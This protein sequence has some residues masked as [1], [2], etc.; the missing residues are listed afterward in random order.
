MTLVIRSRLDAGPLGE[1]VR[2]EL[3]ALDKDVPAYDAKTLR[4]VLD[5]SLA[6]RRFNM[7]LLLVFAFVAV[8][9]A[10]I[11]L[12]GVI[13]Y[14]VTQRTHEIGVRM[15]LGARQA[16]VLKLVVGHG[17]ALAVAGVAAGTLGAL[18]L[19]RVL[20]TLLVGVAVTDPWTYV[21]VASLLTLV[22]LLACYVP[23]RR[24]ARVD[25]MLALR[26]E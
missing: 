26:S 11:G 10:S 22:A 9:L 25:P 15:A 18:A 19:T 23:G 21:A 8:A 3:R 2:R 6:A 16:D 4:E 17:M 20:K 1:S 5:G 14:L 13:A 24:A 12:Y 7:T